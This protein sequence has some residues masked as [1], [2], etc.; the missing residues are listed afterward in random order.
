MSH[1]SDF[2]RGNHA[3]IKV[4]SLNSDQGVR[5]YESLTSKGDDQ[6]FT[7]NEFMANYYINLDDDI[8]IRGIDP[9]YSR[10]LTPGT[11]VF[12]TST[13]YSVENFQYL[14]IETYEIIIEKLGEAGI[15]NVDTYLQNIET[16][17]E[18]G[19]YISTAIIVSRLMTGSFSDFID[20]K[21][22]DPDYNHLFQ[23]AMIHIMFLYHYLQQKYLMV[24]GD[25]KVQNYTW[26]ELPE[27]IDIIYDFRDEY[28]NS[29][30][31]IIRRYNVKHLFYITDFEF[32]YSPLNKVINGD[33]TLRFTPNLPIYDDA[34]EKVY[35]PKISLNDKYVY[36]TSLYGDY[37]F[38]PNEN[39]GATLYDWY[40]PIYPR[41][42]TIDILVLVKMLLTYSYAD[43]F[44]GDTL[45][46]LHIYLTQFISLS[47]Q[48]ERIEYRGG[49]DYRRVSPSMFAKILNS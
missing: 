39:G 49:N 32:V 43:K 38:S 12:V 26:L 21:L 36:N 2:I 33:Y 22:S 40:G 20:N 25:P 27:P 14:S 4:I 19:K 45:R 9:Y 44:N 3:F 46:K 18:Q 24:H 48:E 30:D 16:Y 41:M 28:N 29:D 6:P 47:R 11:E 5:L 1:R 31:R 34:Y 23:D 10:I 35:V 7:S 15:I 37:Q 17:G 13:Q 42:F 8:P